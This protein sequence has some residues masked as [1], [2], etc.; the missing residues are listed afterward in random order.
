MMARASPQETEHGAGRCCNSAGSFPT[1][2]GAREPDG[3]CTSTPKSGPAPSTTDTRVAPA[4]AAA[5]IQALQVLFLS[6]LLLRNSRLAK[7]PRLTA[8]GR[9]AGLPSR[10]LGGV[11]WPPGAGREVGV[12]TAVSVAL[13]GSEVFVPFPGTCGRSRGMGRCLGPGASLRGVPCRSPEPPSPSLAT[14]PQSQPPLP[15]TRP[16]C[17]APPA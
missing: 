4:A 11:S 9:A 2:G 5:K 15:W 12:L 16:P 17:W 13:R 3:T 10:P 14:L 8:C 7:Q 6:G 1:R